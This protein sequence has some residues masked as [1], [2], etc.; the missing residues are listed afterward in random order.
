MRVITIAVVV[1]TLVLGLYIILNHKGLVPEY[2]FGAGAYYYADIPADEYQ[3]ID[4]DGAYQTSVPK[5]VFYV[6]FLAWGWLM[7]RLWIRLSK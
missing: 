6:L 1:I 2:D 4:P 7:W 3:E 5:W